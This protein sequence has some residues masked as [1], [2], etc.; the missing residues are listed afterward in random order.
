[1]EGTKTHDKTTA[2]HSGAAHERGARNPVP[3]GGDDWIPDSLAA[4]GF[5]NGSRWSGADRIP[6]ESTPHPACCARRPLP[7]SG[8]R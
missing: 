1:M 4:L 5:G 6:L 8:T 3:T 2:C 7:A